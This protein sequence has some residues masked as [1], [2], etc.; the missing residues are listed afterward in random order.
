MEPGA[1]RI[2]SMLP[3]NSLITPLFG[4]QDETPAAGWEKIL[5]PCWN[6]LV[7]EVE[8]CLF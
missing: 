4:E 6:P 5:A 1:P 2:Y 8:V 7:R 3:P